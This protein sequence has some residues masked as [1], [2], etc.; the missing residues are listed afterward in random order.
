MNL[1][2][3]WHGKAL[4]VARYGVAFRRYPTLIF[5]NKI[6]RPLTFYTY[7]FAFLLIL[8][9]LERTSS[10]QRTHHSWL[11]NPLSS[12]N[13]RYNKIKASASIYQSGR[14]K[15]TLHHISRLRTFKSN[16]S[17]S[18]QLPPPSSFIVSQGA[19]APRSESCKSNKPPPPPP[20]PSLALLH[21]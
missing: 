6:F 20:N 16:P 10:L 18:K 9:T 15:Q 7:T 11:S 3:R 13:S 21:R 8:T 19:F 1:E 5:V 17:Y 2:D 14:G 12:S 4:H